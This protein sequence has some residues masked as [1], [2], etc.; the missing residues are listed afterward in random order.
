MAPM[1]HS[2]ERPQA[3]GIVAALAAEARPLGP[4]TR[5]GGELAALADGTLISVT[6][7]GGAAAARGARALVAAGCG[8][9]A[10]WGLA[11]GLDPALTCGAILLPEEV[12]LDGGSSLRTASAWRE[13]IAQSLEARWPVR[14]GRLLTSVRA[15]G[16]VADKAAAF[17]VTAAGAVDMESFAV[18]EVAAAHGLPFVA[19]RVIV[20]TAGDELPPALAGVADASGQLSVGRLLR[21][22]VSEPA[23][24]ATLL[25]LARRYRAA[26]RSLRAIVRAGA[27]TSYTP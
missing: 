22:V 16:A 21:S 17:R 13:R 24:I 20:D 7:I 1:R 11:G 23:S 14:Q 26:R 18:A 9:L 15:L 25:R 19:V 27:L 6:G 3:V 8:A 4:A 10:S 2:G 5:R 12:I